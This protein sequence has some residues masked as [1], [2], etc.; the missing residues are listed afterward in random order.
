MQTI[1]M[2]QTLRDVF[3]QKII[4][5]EYL[6]AQVSSR[7]FALMPWFPTFFYSQSK[8]SELL[9]QFYYSVPEGHVLLLLLLLYCI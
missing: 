1:Q 5:F 3:T 8:Y 7:T 6:S 4:L 9:I 2:H